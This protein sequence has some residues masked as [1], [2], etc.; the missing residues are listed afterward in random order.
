MKGW[1]SYTPSQQKSLH[2]AG[3][4]TKE[5]DYSIHY[6]N[7][8]FEVLIQL[9]MIFG[10]AEDYR[11]IVI[12]MKHELILTRSKHRFKCRDTIKGGW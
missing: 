3:F 1:V 4:V 6:L 7:G 5:E 12:N 9:S 8:Y 2:S 11:K 10:F